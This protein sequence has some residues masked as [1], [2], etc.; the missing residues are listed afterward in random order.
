M[1]RLFALILA[2]ASSG[3]LLAQDSVLYVLSFDPGDTLQL[4]SIYGEPIWQ[5]GSP[6]KPVF[7]S[8]WSAPNALVTDTA[9]PFT[10]PGTSYASFHVPWDYYFNNEWLTLS[11]KHRMHVQPGNAFGWVEFYY[12]D[13]VEEWVRAGDMVDLLN[14]EVQWNTTTGLQTDSGMVFTG[15][16]NWTQEQIDFVCW[17]WFTST[18][19][20]SGLGTD[21]MHFRFVF[22]ATSTDLTWDGWMIDDVNILLSP[23]LIGGL[24]DNGLDA[25]E[26][27]PSPTHGKVWITCN[28]LIGTSLSMDVFRSDGVQIHSSNS[29]YSAPIEL[30]LKGRSSGLH[31]IR[32]SAMGMTTVRRVIIQR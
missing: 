12:P 27:G 2:G 6:D 18:Q 4:D 16:W 22:Q 30:D 7:D 14:G 28:D 17:G 8:A 23:C 11:F 21:S 3:A 5:I 10:A 13:P 29:L 31:V 9:L 1:A 32:I 15:S 25:L 19:Y 26:I 20:R 24:A